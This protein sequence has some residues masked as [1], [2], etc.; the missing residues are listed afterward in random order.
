MKQLYLSFLLI[1]VLGIHCAQGQFTETFE[2]LA[3]NQNTFTSNGQPF[4]TDVNGFDAETSFP[5]FGAS[6]SNVFVDNSNSVATED[7]NSI[8]TTDGSNFTLKDV[9]IFLSVDS[10]VTVGGSGSIIIKGK[11]SNVT[12]FTVTISSSSGSI[13]TDFTP[14]NGFFNVDFST[15]GGSDNSLTNIDEVEFELTGSFVYIAIDEFTFGPEEVVADTNPPAVSSI[16]RSGTPPTTADSVDFIVTFNENANNVTTDDFALDITGGAM[17]TISAISGSGTT[18]TVTVN[19]ISGEGTLSIDLNGNTDITDDLGNGNGTNGNSPA[20]TAGEIH[21]VSVCFLESFENFNVNDSAFGSNGLPFMTTGGLDVFNLGGAGASGSDQYLDNGGIGAGSYTIETTGGELFTMNTLD[22]YLSS[23]ASGTPPT[24]NGTLTING[25]VAG[26]T[27]YTITKTTGFPTSLANGDNGFFNINFATEGASDY[28]TTNIDELE[29]VIGGSFVY[30]AVDHF[31]FC[32]EGTTD[33][34]APE[35]LSIAVAGNPTSIDT[36]VDFIVTFNENVTNVTTDDFTLDTS[37]TSGS[38]SSITGSNNIYTVTVDNIAGQGTISIDLNAATDIQDALMNSGPPA[39]TAGENHIVS[40]CFVEDVE[41]FT[42]GA[43]SITS[44][45]VPFTLTN[46]LDVFNQNGAGINGSDLFLDNEGSGAGAYSITTTD[47]SLFTANTM[48][49][50]VSSGATGLAPTDDGTLTIRGKVAGA[51]V[52]SFDLNSGNT[53][54]PTNVSQGNNGFFQVDFATAGASDFSTVDVDEIEIEIFT[55][56][57]YLAIDNF[58]FCQDTT[59]P[60]DPVVTTPATAITVNTATQTIA[61][62]HTENGVTVHAYADN[63]NDGMADN[64]TS[65][66]SAT[67]TGNAWSFSVNLTADS[68]NNFVVQAEDISG[69]TSND[70]DVPTIIEDS[71]TPSGYTALIDQAPINSTNETAVSFTFAAAEVSTTYNYTFTSSGGAGSVTGSGVIATAIDQITGI[72]LSGLADGTITLSVTLT[73]DAGNTGGAATDT[74]T[75]DTGAPTGYNVTID[76]SPI[77]SGSANVVSYTFSSA[78][79]G[80]TYN[81]TFTSSGGAG[82]VTGSGVIATATDQITGIDLS[83]L[84]DGT[85]TL[86]VTLTDVNGNTGS[87]ATDTETKETIRPSVTITSTESPGPTGADPIPVTIT[88]SE[89]VTGFEI[90]DLIVGNGTPGNFAGSGTTY[91]A[92]ITPS[93]AGPLTITVDINADVA[94]DSGGNGNIAAPQFSIDYDNL[95]NINDEILANGL[96]IYPIPSSDNINIS[97]ETSL[98]LQRAE[99]FDIQGKLIISQKLTASSM[100]HTIDISSIRSGLYLMTVYSEKGSTTKRVIKQ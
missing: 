53:A 77:N 97:G 49:V 51:T 57:V 72:D 98:G 34:F 59:A 26:A 55:F 47:N 2:S 45:G 54:F 73:D 19:G 75:K 39:F 78:E 92:D 40:D 8:K 68:D 43:T 48:F 94:L 17:G 36:S 12:Q 95:L 41:S 23:N 85:I 69:N 79:V 27:V 74:E 100:T 91:T 1:T 14:D 44:N 37:G 61:G 42:V 52:F 64:T 67:V 38:I 15:E 18:H 24:N 56:F 4:T 86:S 22:L 35:V 29:I 13:P 65:L 88:F 46:G 25:K 96:T 66:G 21:N 5:G 83:G 99:I 6:G 32:E 81:Y 93:G 87:A 16:T 28:T 58:E 7:I 33:T 62:T 31:E 76:Q 3:D 9:D 84:A 20:F 63:D 30:L 10:G 70:V 71:M 11:E 90:T 89:S 50:Y 60:V 82:S 80:A